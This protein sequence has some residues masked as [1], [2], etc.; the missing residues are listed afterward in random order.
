MFDQG[1]NIFGFMKNEYFQFM[2]ANETVYFYSPQE[3]GK[4]VIL[5]AIKF[6]MAI[7][8]KYVKFI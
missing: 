4:V 3:P 8:G 7:A 2:K 1:T 6:E 5:V